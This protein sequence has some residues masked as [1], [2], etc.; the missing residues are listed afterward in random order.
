MP[1]AQTE[2]GAHLDGSVDVIGDAIDSALRAGDMFLAR[3]CDR[4]PVVE[5]LVE[6]GAGSDLRAAQSALDRLEA[7]PVTPGFVM[8]ESQLLRM[9]ALLTRGPR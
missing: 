7:V 9:R 1:R 8:H 3:P 4:H 5:A 6:R 2:G